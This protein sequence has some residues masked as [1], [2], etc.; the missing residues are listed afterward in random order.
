MVI[1]ICYFLFKQTLV[2]T[3]FFIFLSN[4]LLVLVLE[5]FHSFV[6]LCRFMQLAISKNIFFLI[7]MQMQGAY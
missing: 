6:Y 2:K 5:I 7:Q 3:D 4:L 1:E